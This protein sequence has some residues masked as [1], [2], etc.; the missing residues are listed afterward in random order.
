MLLQLIPV[1]A[2]AN[3]AV[4][5]IQAPS[6]MPKSG[7]T[8]EV[9][10]DLSNNPGFCAIQFTLA[11]DKSKMECDDIMLVGILEKGLTATNPNKAEG[12]VV[13]AASLKALSGDGPIALYTF[14]A[15]EDIS[16]FGF[17]I[18]DIILTDENNKDIDY[19]VVGGN[20]EENVPAPPENLPDEEEITDE[21]EDVYP[22]YTKEPEEVISDDKDV[23]EEETES[24]PTS[25]EKESDIEGGEIDGVIE[26]IFP[27][28]IG[29]W[30]ESFVGEA[31]KYGLFKGD[32]EGNFNPDGNIT[33][34]QFVTVLWR[35]AGE[36]TVNIELPFKDIEN[37]IPEF[38]EAIAWGYANGYINGISET[39][40]DPDGTLTREAGM[41]IL[42][43]YSGRTSGMELQ[44][45]NIYD[46]SFEDSEQISPWAKNSV[47]WGFYNKLISGTSETTLSPQ[48]TASRGQMAKILVNYINIFSK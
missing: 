22:E 6:E 5:S 48:G 29:H 36:P 34:A 12:A 37:Q 26:I 14:T 47:Y 28:V 40:F 13:A 4:F 27:D 30:A 32:T 2:A 19:E 8:F 10:V 42:H 11:Y 16:D 45:P 9:S 38:K 24:L 23:Y 3:D 46:G 31:V 15:K 21:P 7:E 35:M 44:L 1:S 18:R 17:K 25:P 20:E 39:A 41:K 33:R 43:Y